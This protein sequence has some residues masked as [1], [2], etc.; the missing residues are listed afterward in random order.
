MRYLLSGQEDPRVV[1]L[2]L[3]I[4]RVENEDHVSAIYDHLVK[5]FSDTDAAKINSVPQSNFNRTMK[6]VHKAAEVFEKLFE[7][8]YKSIKGN[9]NV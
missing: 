7:L 8:K 5:G 1:D 3:E 9:T 6:R 4:V 2:L